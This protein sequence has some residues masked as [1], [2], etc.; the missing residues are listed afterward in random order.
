V[1]QALPPANRRLPAAIV[2]GPALA[3]RGGPVQLDGGVQADPVARAVFDRDD[4][5][6]IPT[7]LSIQAYSKAWSRSLS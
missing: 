3:R 1:G 2:D 7:W 5:L 4:Y 6:L